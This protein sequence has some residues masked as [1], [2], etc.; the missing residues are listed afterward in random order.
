MARHSSDIL[1]PRESQIMDVLWELDGATSEQVRER[2]SGD[3]HDSS[4][5]TL[6]RVLKTKGY[7]RQNSKVRPTVYRPAVSRHRVQQ[8]AAKNLL[9]RFF[10]GSAE[11]LVLRLLEDEQLTPQQLDRLKRSRQSRRRKGGKP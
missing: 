5:R 2:L 3:P 9:Q 6:L 4:V 7:V 11:A 8:K 10:S 1:T